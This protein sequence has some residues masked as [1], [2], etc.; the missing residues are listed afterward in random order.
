MSANMNQPPAFLSWPIDARVSEASSVPTPIVA[1]SMLV[2]KASAPSSSSASF[3]SRVPHG[4]ADEQSTHYQKDHERPNVGRLGD[5]AEATCQIGEPARLQRRGLRSDRRQVEGNQGEEADSEHGGL[6]SEAPAYPP[7]GDAYAANRWASQLREVLA[8]AR[9]RDAFIRRRGSTIVG[10]I[11]WRAGWLI[12]TA[13][14]R[15]QANTSARPIDIAPAQMR[16]AARSEPTNPK[17]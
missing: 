2:P 5:E 9:E 6:D 7:D 1:K 13:A 4:L 14:P 10:T 11:A 12:A 3:G 15:T 16:T 8:G 17:I